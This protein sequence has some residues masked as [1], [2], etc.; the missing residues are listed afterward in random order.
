MWSFVVGDE[1]RKHNTV[2][3]YFLYFHVKYIID[4]V[5]N[6]HEKGWSENL[7]FCVNIKFFIFVSVVMCFL[8]F[9]QTHTFINDW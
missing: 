3:I 1:C 2:N 5:S 4:R 6:F 9:P 8:F 7:W